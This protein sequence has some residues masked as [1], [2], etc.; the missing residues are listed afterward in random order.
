MNDILVELAS[1]VEEL[2]IKQYNSGSENEE[3]NYEKMIM[4]LNKVYDTLVYLGV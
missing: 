2:R 3:K 1:V 4:I